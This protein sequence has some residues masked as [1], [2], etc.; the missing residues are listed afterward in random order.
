MVFNGRHCS[1]NADEAS[2]DGLQPNAPSMMAIKTGLLRQASTARVHRG[3]S[4]SGTTL[5]TEPLDQ[6]NP[7]Y[8]T[9]FLD[10]D[11]GLIR[12]QNLKWRGVWIA[13]G[14][15]KVRQL[16]YIHVKCSGHTHKKRERKFS[17]I[18]LGFELMFRLGSQATRFQFSRKFGVGNLVIPV[19]HR[20]QK[21]GGLTMYQRLN[22]GSS[23]RHFR[24]DLLGHL[25]NP[26]C[27]L[28]SKPKRNVYVSQN[29][30]SGLL[31]FMP[32]H[33]AI[34]PSKSMGGPKKEH[35]E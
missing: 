32:D 19:L 1:A 5:L 24:F 23:Q 8:A 2:N 28:I 7:A 30:F 16:E 15:L 22:L 26:G 25:N 34:H 18:E 6:C 3:E 21:H 20:F 27:V 33:P 11:L 14:R 10:H 17:S 4:H 12:H 9:L 29:G 31:H 35:S 13:C